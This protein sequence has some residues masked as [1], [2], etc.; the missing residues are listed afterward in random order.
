[1][2]RRARRKVEHGLPLA[3]LP[4]PGARHPRQAEQDGHEPVRWPPRRDDEFQQTRYE[5]DDRSPGI[6]HALLDDVETGPG[7][8][9]PAVGS[10]R[11]PHRGPVII[12]L[13]VVLFVLLVVSLT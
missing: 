3:P 2:N 13:S 1:M 4:P 11:R 5:G 8:G 10:W 6:R 12:V 9:S 7:D